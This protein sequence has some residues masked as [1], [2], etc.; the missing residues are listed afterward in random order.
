LASS[1]ISATSTLSILFIV[2]CREPFY[3]ALMLA[4]DTWSKKISL[5]ALVAFTL[6]VAHGVSFA[7]VHGT[8]KSF[9][10]ME[11]FSVFGHSATIWILFSACLLFSAFIAAFL[12]TFLVLLFLEIIARQKDPKP[13]KAPITQLITSEQHN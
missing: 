5:A 12:N 11:G 7:L 4:L 6:L 9:R 13:E 2:L 3:K 8:L 1:V 10:N